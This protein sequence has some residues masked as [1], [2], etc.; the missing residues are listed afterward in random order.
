N[1]VKDEF[2][3]TVSHELRTPLNALLGW[4]DMLRMGILPVDRRQR[5]LDSV[6]ENAKLQAQLISDLLD[7]A[8]ILTGKLRMETAQVDLAQVIHDAVDVVAPAAQSKG[9]AIEVSIDDDLGSFVGDAG[10]LQ[11]V[12]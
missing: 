4:A 7:T 2:L 3:M 8:R 12:V 9:L 11:Q 10:R 1:R 6:Y 5:A